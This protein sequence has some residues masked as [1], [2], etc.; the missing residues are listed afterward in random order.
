VGRGDDHFVR[1]H[2]VMGTVG[3]VNLKGDL[4][5]GTSFLFAERS[6]ISMGKA[7]IEEKT[8]HSL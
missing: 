7:E 3:L 2:L 4:T 6:L 5:I 8:M 1:K